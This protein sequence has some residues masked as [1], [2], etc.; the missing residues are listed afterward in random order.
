MKLSNREVENIRNKL[1]ELNEK[2]K[3]DIGIVDVENTQPIQPIQ[4]FSANINKGPKTISELNEPLSDYFYESDILLTKSQLDSVVQSGNRQKR[5]A[6]SDAF[7]KWPTKSAISYHISGFL[8]KRT[9]TIIHAAFD[10]WQKRTCLKFVQVTARRAHDSLRFIKGSGCYSY[11]GRIGGPQPISIGTGCEYFGIVAHEIGHALGFFHEQARFD[12]DEYLT[13]NVENV[14]PSRIGNFDK[15]NMH[16]MN[17]YDIPY[18][19]GSLM[20]YSSDEFAID[21]MSPVL[22]ARD[23]LFQQTIGQRLAPTFLDVLEMNRHYQCTELCN[24]SQTVCNNGGYSNPR[25]CSECNCPLGFNGPFCDEALS[26]TNNKTCGAKIIAAEDWKETSPSSRIELQIMNLTTECHSGCYHNALQI[27]ASQNVQLTGYRFC[28]AGDVKN[29]TL[30]SALHFA[31]VIAE[32]SS[33]LSFKI[34]YR[35][36]G[37]DAFTHTTL[38]HDLDTEANST[39][40]STTFSLITPHIEIQTSTTAASTTFIFCFNFPVNVFDNLLDSDII[41]TSIDFTVIRDHN[42][43]YCFT[44]SE[45]EYYLDCFFYNNFNNSA[46]YIDNDVVLSYSAFFFTIHINKRHISIIIINHFASY[47][48]N[49]S[50]TSGSTTT[51][52][53]TTGPKAVSTDASWILSEWSDWSNCKLVKCRK[54]P[55]PSYGYQHKSRTCSTAT[56]QLCKGLRETFRGCNEKKCFRYRTCCMPSQ[57]LSVKSRK[58]VCL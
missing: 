27:K 4:Q 48:A 46:L 45:R 26:F 49:D 31:V 30:T 50:R 54:S 33:F 11:V 47:F 39:V 42:D 13:L 22:I 6:V 15:R 21:K 58:I 53:T 34:K 56:D 5:K 32:V 16:E 24:G 9:K 18:E 52:A 38:V 51:S 29:R 43:L 1:R 8:A 2:V 10:Y 55:C 7:S 36:V 12:R 23:A 20:H 35:S 57:K 17:T 37:T 41:D 19:Y 3:A 25:N 14:W 28:C 40:S 44:S